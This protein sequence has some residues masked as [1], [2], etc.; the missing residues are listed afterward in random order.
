[1][2]SFRRQ[3]ASLRMDENGI[4][5]I[6]ETYQHDI[7][8]D[9]VT[10]VL[11]AI[12]ELHREGK[13]ILTES[14]VERSGVKQTPLYV[15]LRWLQCGD[16]PWYKTSGKSREFRIRDLAAWERGVAACIV[17]TDDEDDVTDWLVADVFGDPRPPVVEEP[18]IA[19]EGR[20]SASSDTDGSAAV[21]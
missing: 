16:V 5:Y 17:G 8:H 11:R 15:L 14:M 19:D 4:H 12:R 21:G 1:M 2:T 20:P 13:R 10:A 6:A 18:E 3:R 9:Q 7:R